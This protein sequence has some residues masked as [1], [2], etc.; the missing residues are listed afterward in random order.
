MGPSSLLGC[1]KLVW[2]YIPPFVSS[3]NTTS[4]PQPIHSSKQ[5]VFLESEQIVSTSKAL[6]IPLLSPY[7]SKQFE[8]NEA[9]LQYWQVS[10]WTSGE[11]VFAS[12]W[13]YNA[14]TKTVTI[15]SS[16]V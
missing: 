4:L 7:F 5:Q 1:W 11:E 16:T 15:K 10:D 2:L 6:K 9:S 14:T 8:V 13:Q 3:I 12:S